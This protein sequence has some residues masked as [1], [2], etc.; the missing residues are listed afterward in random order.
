MVVVLVTDDHLLIPRFVLTAMSETL[1]KIPDLAIDI[2]ITATRQDRLGSRQGGGGSPREKVYP[3]PFDEAGAEAMWILH[4]VLTTW[5]RHVLEYRQ[6]TFLP[7]GYTHRHGEFIGPLRPNERRVP[8]GY[9]VD[10]PACLAKWL[11]AH[12]ISLAMTEG[13]EEAPHEIKDA[14]TQAFA[15][16][17]RPPRERFAFITDEKLQRARKT[18]LNAAGIVSLAKELG[19]AVEGLN[20]KRF[21]TLL[22]A[23]ILTP[24]PGPW[25][26]DYPTLYIVGEVFDAHEKYPSRKS[27]LKISA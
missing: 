1:R 26:P 19:G 22:A 3:L 9:N 20:K 8:P 15:C 11:D 23:G 12:L 16:T 17:D 6:M 27:R 25:R 7:V 24:A 13:C 14:Y 10:T 21:E 5:V 18:R 2:E 4:N